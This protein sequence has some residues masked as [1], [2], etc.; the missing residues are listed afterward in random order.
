MNDHILTAT[1]CK[2]ARALLG[3]HMNDLAKYA[4]VSV[5]TIA[6]FENGR[7][8]PIPAT[9]KALRQALE[10]AGVRFTENKADFKMWV[11]MTTG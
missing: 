9:Q 6:D 7:D 1:Q 11:V 8:M 4:S 2:M 5:G 10:E 3:W